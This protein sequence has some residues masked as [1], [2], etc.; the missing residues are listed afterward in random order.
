MKIRVAAIQVPFTYIS[1]PQEFMDLMRTP[2]ERAARDS[3]ELIVLPNYLGFALLGMFMADAPATMLLDELAQAQR[4]DSVY[5]MLRERAEYLFD[6]YVHIFQSLAPRVQ[7][8]LLPGTAPEWNE[9]ELYNTALLFSP[10]GQV[11]GQQRQMHRSVEE[12][13]WGFAAATDLRVFKTEVGNLGIVI[14]EDVRYPEVSRILALQGANIL[15]HPAASRTSH[16]EQFLVDI[17]REVQSNQVFGIQANLVGETFQGRSAI[18]APVEYTPDHRGFV[19]RAA[20]DSELEIVSADLDFDRLQQVVDEYP[21]FD[22]FNHAL[23]RNLGK[24][25]E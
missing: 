23:Y 18:Y 4:F 19:V 14:G 1:T 22:F 15:I 24:T 21:I 10:A 6:F 12:R 17:W 16:H 9:G 5:E 8:W 25:A 13:A 11:L 2:I 3:A 7:A 20:T